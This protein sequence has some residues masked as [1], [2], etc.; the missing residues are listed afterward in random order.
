MMIVM[1]L[2]FLFILALTTKRFAARMLALAAIAPCALVVIF[3]LSRGGFLG[4]AAVGLYILFR[5]HHKKWLIGLAAV[6]IMAGLSMV[7]PEFYA[8]I[9]TVNHAAEQDASS[10]G[11]INAW[12][13]ALAMVED[14][15]LTGVGVGNFLVHFRRYAPDPDDP[16]VAHSSFFQILGDAGL[17][18]VLAWLSIVAGIFLAAVRVERRMKALDRGRWSDER[19]CIMVVK[20]SLLG[21]VVCGAFLSMEDF[22]FLFQLLAITSRLG[23]WT[24]AREQ[25]SSAQAVAARVSPPRIELAGRG[26][27]RRCSGAAAPA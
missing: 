20:A 23:A 3:S 11:R 9:G 22:D 24:L 1:A 12:H 10:R 7:P 6:G 14:R 27:M 4:L 5:L 21:Y 8:R 19:Y 2:P 26:G 13:A 18:G 17:P 15:P 16:H 25:A